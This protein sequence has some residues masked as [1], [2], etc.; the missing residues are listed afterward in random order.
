MRGWGHPGLIHVTVMAV[1]LAASGLN[2]RTVQL[3][4]DGQRTLSEALA[5]QTVGHHC[6]LETD[7]SIASEP[8]GSLAGPIILER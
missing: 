7:Y 6:V 5:D 2:A 1:L 3:T 8:P 4:A